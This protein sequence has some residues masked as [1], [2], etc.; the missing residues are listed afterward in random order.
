[1]SRP[2]LVTV[3]IALSA[4]A[5]ACGDGGPGDLAYVG[6]YSL[7]SVG[8]T[9]LPVAI[10]VSYSG[11]DQDTTVITDGTLALRSD[12]SFSFSDTWIYRGFGEQESGS[13]SCTGEYGIEPDGDFSTDGAIDCND[14]T[15]IDRVDGTWTG[16][17]L[18]LSLVFTELGVLTA[19]FTR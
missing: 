7:Q 1:M 6:T 12:G 16:D 19:V 2:L 3:L 13:S 4:A 11:G 15:E 9:S 8:G 14:E 10:I 18:E 17:R 5:L